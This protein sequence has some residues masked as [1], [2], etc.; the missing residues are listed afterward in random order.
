MRM[1]H[2]WQ[3]SV[4]PCDLNPRIADLHPFCVAALHLRPP[5]VPRH[6]GAE[7]GTSSSSARTSG[8]GTTVTR[9]ST[10]ARRSAS[11]PWSPSPGASTTGTSSAPW[12]TVRQGRGLGLLWGRYKQGSKPASSSEAVEATYLIGGGVRLKHGGLVCGAVLL[13]V[14]RADSLLID[15]IFVA[16]GW[17]RDAQ[18]DRFRRGRPAA[19]PRRPGL[20]RRPQQ[21]GQGGESRAGVGGYVGAGC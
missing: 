16:M 3:A 19:H 20:P 14:W 8:P 21:Q 15:P 5:A 9:C 11:G 1:Q 18:Q 4:P 13:P 7:T 12:R 17:P 10:T 2:P 6:T